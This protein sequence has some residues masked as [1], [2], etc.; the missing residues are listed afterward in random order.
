MS[1]RRSQF[2]TGASVRFQSMVQDDS[3]VLSYPQFNDGI[4]TSQNAVADI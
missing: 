2:R 1:G 4:L 3:P